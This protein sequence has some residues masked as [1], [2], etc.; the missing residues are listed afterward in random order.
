MAR[1][2]YGV[3][4]AVSAAIIGCDP[5]KELPPELPAK[6]TP[7]GDRAEAV[8][9]AS[10]PAAKAYI[11][12]AVLAYTGGKP[13][14][15]PKGKYSRVQLKGRQYKLDTVP[16][17]TTR[18]IAAVWPDRFTATDVRESRGIRVTISAYLHRPR[19]TIREG[20]EDKDLPNQVE[21][22]RNLTIDETAQH[23]MSLLL[24]P[25]DPKAIVFDLQALTRPPQDAQPTAV[26]TVKV[27]LG[28]F[29][30]YTLTFDTKT[31]ALVAVDYLHTERGVESRKQ[32]LVL[33]H[34]VGP[35]GL[36]LPN[37]MMFKWN[38]DVV[39]EWEVVKWEFPPTIKDE[40]FSPPQK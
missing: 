25:T 40:E 9:A 20:N 29:P 37:K 10:H 33:E 5:A 35:E 30:V 11:D 27:A 8:P 21:I 38:G 36:L 6:T 12:K 34:K 32:W 19:I 7:P 4:L 1:L 17:E 28:D 13:E 14:L 2:A 18:D 3:L 26:Q 39:E 15:L 24:P 31:D 23:W 22:E 16:V